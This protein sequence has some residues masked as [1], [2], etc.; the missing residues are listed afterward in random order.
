MRVIDTSV[1]LKWVVAEDRSNTAMLL[2]GQPFRAPDLL[3]GEAAHGLS[4]RCREG[5]IDAADAFIGQRLIE[6]SVVIVSSEFLSRRALELSL[7]LR[8]PAADCFFLALAERQ[9]TTF[10]TADRKF[11]ERCHG[12]RYEQIIEM[13]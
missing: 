1:V 4:R 12:T 13:L 10:V 2:I 5:V 8:H 3:R 9:R 11:V 7:E 6:R